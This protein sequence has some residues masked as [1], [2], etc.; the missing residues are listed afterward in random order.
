MFEQLE[1]QRPIAVEVKNVTQSFRVIHERP[2]TVREVFAR[3]FSLS[4]N[5]TNHEFL[6]LRD[7]FLRPGEG[8]NVGHPRA[9]WFRQEHVA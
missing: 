7:V 8:Q 9:Q 3:Y 4:R 1:M 2:D 5:P 6:A